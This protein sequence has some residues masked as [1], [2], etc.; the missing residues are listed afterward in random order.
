M[1]FV[2]EISG[3]ESALWKLGNFVF[4]S[5]QGEERRQR[6]EKVVL[7]EVRSFAEFAF[8]KTVVFTAN[9]S[10]RLYTRMTS[11]VSIRPSRC[12]K[13]CYLIFVLNGKT[14]KGFILPSN[15]WRLLWAE[16]SIAWR[17]HGTKS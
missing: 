8:V 10:C 9:K 12:K 7:P 3:L 16:T 11:G 14:S 15:H 17:L 4:Y 2:I 13:A 5:G 1:E 6:R